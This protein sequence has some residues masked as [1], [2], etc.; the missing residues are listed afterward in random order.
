MAA[1][2]GLVGTLGELDVDET[3]LTQTESGIDLVLHGKTMP[4]LDGLERIATVAHDLD[5]ARVS[6][7]GPGL[8]APLAVR[9]MPEFTFG[10]VRVATPAGA[11]VQATRWG[12]DLMAARIAEVLGS[13]GEL[14][15]LYAGLGTFGLRLLPE[16]KI[17]AV[18]GSRA[19]TEAMTQAAGQAGLAGRF[20]ALERDLAHAPMT[21]AELARFDAV[22]FDPPRQGAREQSMQIAASSV[23][24][25]VAASCNPVSFGR[26]ARILVDGGYRLDT[27]WPI[28]QFLWSHHLELVA[29][30]RRG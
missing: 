21:A 2:A 22:I 5:L 12:E 6:W 9:R 26:D 23:P 7:H 20:T 13:S 14:A 4:D 3:E 30:F 29:V 19:M 24:L 16:R 1:R 8:R 27:I 28:D 17:T 11:F 10:Q 15:D 25:V 18:E